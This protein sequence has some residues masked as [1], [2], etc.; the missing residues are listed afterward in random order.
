MSK[1][2]SKDVSYAVLHSVIHHPTV[3]QYGPVFQNWQDSARKATKMTL[4]E[5]FLVLEIPN[6]KDK[7]LSVKCLVPL[8]NVVH[9][10]LE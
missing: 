1:F 7:K 2:D 6:P 9:F 10:V 3:G 8:T 4:Q 5:P